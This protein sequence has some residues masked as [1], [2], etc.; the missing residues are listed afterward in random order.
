ML[1]V[2]VGRTLEAEGIYVAH[3]NAKGVFPCRVARLPVGSKHDS[4]IA[5]ERKRL[6]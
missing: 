5:T 3:V 1:L 6:L 2:V 4:Y